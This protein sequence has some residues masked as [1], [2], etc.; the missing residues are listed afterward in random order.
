LAGLENNNPWVRPP[1]SSD[2][3]VREME[4]EEGLTTAAAVVVVVVVVQVVAASVEIAELGLVDGVAVVVEPVD[5]TTTFFC[6]SSRL[7]RSLA[8]SARL[9]LTLPPSSSENI[10][11]QHRSDFSLVGAVFARVLGRPASCWT[12]GGV[13]DVVTRPGV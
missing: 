9:R 13:L 2:N 1:P 7:R 12:P 5:T 6:C 10:L 4:V 3:V 11:V 8:S